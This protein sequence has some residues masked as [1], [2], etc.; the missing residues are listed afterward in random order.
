MHKCTHVNLGMMAIFFSGSERQL[1]ERGH[2]MKCMALNDNT[3]VLCVLFCKHL[4]FR[5][6]LKT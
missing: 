6:W 2:A 3:W 1:F 4:H 5:S